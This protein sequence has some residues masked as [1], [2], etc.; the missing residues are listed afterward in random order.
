MILASR[1]VVEQSYR[2]CLGVMSLA[3]KEGGDTRLED[4]CAQ[5]LSYTPTPSY[6]MVKRLWADW[7]PVLDPGLG[8][9]GETGFTRGA[10]YYQ[11]QG[12]QP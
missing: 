1:K 4:A 8:S 6:T 7:Q 2:S 9:L 11:L 12:G 10:G 3:K 5:A